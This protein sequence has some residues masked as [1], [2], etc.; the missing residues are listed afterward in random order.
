MMVEGIA[1]LALTVI[2]LAAVISIAYNVYHRLAWSD[3][4]QRFDNFI[5]V[6][7]ELPEGETKEQSL[8]VDIDGAIFGFAKASDTL[9]LYEGEKAYTEKDVKHIYVLQRPK[10]C[11]KDSACICFCTRLDVTKRHDGTYQQNDVACTGRLKCEQFKGLDLEAQYTPDNFLAN[12]LPIKYI[13]EG[14]FLIGS[15]TYAAN[16]RLREFILK[17]QKQGSLLDLSGVSTGEP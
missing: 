13:H 1:R 11:S 2:A 12:S 14:G 9:N 15:S 16:P 6:V 17:I 5:S 10:E 3:A 4:E 8:A 7:K